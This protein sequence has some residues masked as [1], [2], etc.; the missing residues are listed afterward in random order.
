MQ[1]SVYL[2]LKR[3]ELIW[4]KGNP[5]PAWLKKSQSDETI[6]SMPLLSESFGVVREKSS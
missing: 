4:I 3:K 1:H 6:P 2:Q 5:F